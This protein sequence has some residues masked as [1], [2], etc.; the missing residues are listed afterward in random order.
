[1]YLQ[2]Q[3]LAGQRELVLQRAFVQLLAREVVA[4][5]LG[6]GRVGLQRV[7]AALAQRELLGPTGQVRLQVRRLQAGARPLPANRR[8][9]R[10]EAQ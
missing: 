8:R 6:E 7:H 2:R 1:V 3:R 4:V 10:S 9:T 5:V